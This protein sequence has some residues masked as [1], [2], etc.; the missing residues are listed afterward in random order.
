MWWVSSSV[1]QTLSPTSTDDNILRLSRYRIFADSRVFSTIRVGTF[2]LNLQERRPPSPIPARVRRQSPPAVP[3]G[4]SFAYPFLSRGAWKQGENV[5]RGHSTG[6]P[7]GLTQESPCGWASRLCTPS[8]KRDCVR[9]WT[10]HTVAW[11]TRGLRRE[12]EVLCPCP[13]LDWVAFSAPLHLPALHAELKTGS[14]S[15]AKPG[16]GGGTHAGVVKGRAPTAFVPFPPP[17]LSYLLIPRL[18][19]YRFPGRDPQKGLG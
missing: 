11:R 10:H 19:Q 14:I 2:S 18:L 15:L 7:H 4:D 12:D 16:S 13:P 9:G 1:D 5:T 8:P 17:V 6:R 3:R